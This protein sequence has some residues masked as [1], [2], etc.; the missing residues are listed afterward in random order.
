M[1]GLIHIYCGDGKGKTTASVGLAVRAAGAGKQVLF[2]Q[3]FKDGSSSEI[4]VLSAIH[5]IEVEFCK[6]QYGFFKN[7]SE[8][9]RE[10]VQQEY[11]KLLETV[12]QRSAHTVDLLVLDEV[13]SACNHG[14]V[15]EEYLMNFLRNKPN[16]LEVVLT[17]RNPSDRLLNIADYISEMCKRKHPFDQGVKARKGIEF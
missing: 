3:F 15:S 13:I 16:R 5:G 6:T 17:G 7:M 10:Q 12:L 4:E 8:Q 1:S 9:T 11:S 14:V 2:A